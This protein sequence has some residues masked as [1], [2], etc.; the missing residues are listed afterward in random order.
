MPYY[1]FNKAAPIND[2]SDLAEIL[3]LQEKQWTQYEYEWE[4]RP[5]QDETRFLKIGYNRKDPGGTPI[6]INTPTD[7][8]DYEV[9]NILQLYISICK[10]IT[11]TNVRGISYNMQ[12]FE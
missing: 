4:G 1:F 10:P 8:T 7:H 5:F 11:I 2:L 6:V 3:G 9:L 12:E